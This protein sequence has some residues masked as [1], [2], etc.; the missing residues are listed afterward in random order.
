MYLILNEA[1]KYDKFLELIQEQT[2]TSVYHDKDGN[3]K[4]IDLANS[5]AYLK[6]EAI[7]PENVTVVGGKTGTT[8]AA[9][10]CLII[11]EMLP[12]THIFLLFC[13]LR[14]ERYFIQK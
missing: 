11:A 5:N 9:G 3:E 13:R 10:N 7:A 6:G 14:T 2:Y 1:V 4:K 8:N 12:A